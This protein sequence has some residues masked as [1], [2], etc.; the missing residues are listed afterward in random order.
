MRHDA[1]IG[2]LVRSQFLRREARECRS[3]RFT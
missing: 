2:P 3:A 1:Q